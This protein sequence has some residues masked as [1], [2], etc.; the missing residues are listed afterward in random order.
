MKL[1]GAAIKPR[2]LATARPLLPV[3]AS[4]R[5]EATCLILEH[6][7]VQPRKQNAL[8]QVMLLANMVQ[9]EAGARQF[10]QEG[11]GE[12]E[13]FHLGT[14]LRMA[15]V[16]P[17]EMP[18]AATVAANVTA[19][20]PL[21]RRLVASKDLDLAPALVALMKCP[22]RDA[23][24]GAARA[25]RNC[26]ADAERLAEVAALPGVIDAAL[27]LVDGESPKELENDVRAVRSVLC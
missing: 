1:R 7:T 5:S 10:L 8:A 15:H 16:A 19:A 22:D 24:A 9:D 11:R 12:L 18:H 26:A 6:V 20:A 4:H 13:G 3:A 27:R 14:L 17:A 21:G 23:R 2:S 25:L